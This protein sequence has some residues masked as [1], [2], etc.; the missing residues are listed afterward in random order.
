MNKL[1]GKR[2]LVLEDEPI[3]A[4]MLEDML[5]E[6][7]CDVVGPSDRV[8]KALDLARTAQ[9]DLAI[10]DVN[11][12]GER[13]YPVAAALEGR[14]IPFV[15]ATGYSLTGREGPLRKR[16]ILSKPYQASQ[17]AAALAELV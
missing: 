9:I 2:V 7:G 14:A 3:V 17:L 15:F 13:S 4:M 10:L 12:Q 8:D 11:I 6:L 16:P 5:L 1:A